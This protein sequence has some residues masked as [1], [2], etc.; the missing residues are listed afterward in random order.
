[1][2]QY[3]VTLNASPAAYGRCEGA[4]TYDEYSALQ[5]VAIP[6]E[7]YNFSRWSD[8]DTSATRT[9]LVTSD[10]TLT[11]YFTSGNIYTV[12]ID[13][14][15]AGGSVTG[16]NTYEEGTQVTVTATPNTGYEFGG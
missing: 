3:T 16:A 14:D 2:A 12:S 5:I 6:N 9:I 7:G 10:I 11:A 13:Y 8:G 1:M 15:T 4:G